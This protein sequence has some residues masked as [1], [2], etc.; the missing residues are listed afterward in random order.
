[1]PSELPQTRQDANTG[2]IEW[3]PLDY[4]NEART[5]QHGKEIDSAFTS[6]IRDHGAQKEMKRLKTSPTREESMRADITLPSAIKLSQRYRSQYNPAKKEVA[7]SELYPGQYRGEINARAAFNLAGNHDPVGNRLRVS[8]DKSARFYDGRTTGTGHIVD[9]S[10]TGTHVVIPQKGWE[11][12]QSQ[13]AA[14]AH[15]K[16]EME[17][18]LNRLHGGETRVHQVPGR[19]PVP[20][21]QEGRLATQVVQPQ[22]DRRGKRQQRNSRRSTHS[23]SDSSVFYNK[24]YNHPSMVVR[25]GQNRDFEGR[26]EITGSA[27]Q[28][29]QRG[30]TQEFMLDKRSRGGVYEVTRAQGPTTNMYNVAGTF[31]QSRTGSNS[32]RD[33]FTR[34]E[35]GRDTI[36]AVAANRATYNSYGLGQS[37]IPESER[38]ERS[39]V[40]PAMDA[41]APSEMRGTT[42]RDQMADN[43]VNKV[44]A[45]TPHTFDEHP[46]YVGSFSRHANNFRQDDGFH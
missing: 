12:V 35:T 36:G 40:K 30:S 22:S 38:I 42:Q 41:M 11:E 15:V 44:I 20:F 27:Y 33:D 25:V 43:I 6:V 4:I 23:Y 2:S 39:W 8:V 1:M 28:L 21:S 7:N 19:N 34:E 29:D 17:A 3:R 9:S 13:R 26:Q 37:Y 46:Y 14:R 16:V 32:S 18:M 24:P 10:S 5:R 45:P 31:L